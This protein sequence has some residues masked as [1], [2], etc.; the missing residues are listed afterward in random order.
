MVIKSEAKAKAKAKAKAPS[1]AKAKD[2]AKPS[3]PNELPEW[4]SFRDSNKKRG[5]LMLL[6]LK[7]PSRKE[8][9]RTGKWSCLDDED[10]QQI[11]EGR[12]RHMIAEPRTVAWHQQRMH[13]LSH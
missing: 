6:D 11:Y 2:K 3:D 10:M 1:M 13:V 5:A 9:P 12:K 4:S 7:F 8:D